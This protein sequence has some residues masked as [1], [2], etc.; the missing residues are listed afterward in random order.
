MLLS[1][2]YDAPDCQEGSISM[3]GDCLR[4]ESML[5]G[6]PRP[7]TWQSVGSRDQCA[8]GRRS[9]WRRRLPHPL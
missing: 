3:P 9:A 5:I 1:S 6:H 7:R 2:Y 8:R 4:H